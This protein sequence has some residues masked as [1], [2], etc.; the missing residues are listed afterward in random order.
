[1]RVKLHFKV[2]EL[3]LK[4]FVFK[5]LPLVIELNPPSGGS[6]CHCNT[7]NKNIGK[8]YPHQHKENRW[9]HVLGKIS[10]STRSSARVEKCLLN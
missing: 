3:G 5:R 9:P 4:I 8:E 10:S 2:V 6:D 1:M 7:D